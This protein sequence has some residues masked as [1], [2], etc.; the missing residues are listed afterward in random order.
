M[1]KIDTLQKKNQKQ[2]Q[3]IQYSLNKNSKVQI[4]E[5]GIFG[6][7]GRADL[8]NH[9]K[10]RKQRFRYNYFEEKLYVRF[11]EKLK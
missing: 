5:I 1:I 7:F 4:F 6:R 2:K 8:R 9:I 3:Q 11:D 10:Q